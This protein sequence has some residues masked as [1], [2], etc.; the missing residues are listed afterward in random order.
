MDEAFE[1]LARA[2]AIAEEIGARPLL[3]RAHLALGEA[4]EQSGDV[5]RA[6]DHYKQFYRVKSEVAA[7]EASNKL[8]QLQAR[9]ELERLEKEAEVNRLKAERMEHELLL[10]R[11]VQLNLLPKSP[12]VIEGIDIASICVPALEAG[13]DYYDFFPLD[14]GRLGVAIGDV[15]GK[16][17]PAAIYMTLVKGIMASHATASS[18]PKDLLVRANR[19]VYQ[20]FSRGSFVSMIYAV[21]DP[22]ARTLTYARAGH[23]PLLLLRGGEMIAQRAHGGMALGLAG[24]ETFA[25]AITEVSLQLEA[26]DRLLLYTD[27][28]SE[29]MNDAREDYGDSRLLG[30]ALRHGDAASARDLLDA[31]NDDLL[32]FTG[33]ALQHDDMTMIVLRFE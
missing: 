24:T 21:I 5:V 17:M 32:A 6:L 25:G 4:F 31:V 33:D 20:T 26:G 18:S 9:L 22:V 19:L 10:A 11:K 16:G 12:P 30:T 3:Y 14:D 28:F 23:N 27:G 29:A 1:Q 8:R 2:L 13:G 15:T 7:E